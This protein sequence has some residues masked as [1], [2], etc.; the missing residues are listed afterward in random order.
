MFKPSE[1]FVGLHIEIAGL[2]DIGTT[3]NIVLGGLHL[4]N[5]DRT[6]DLEI[7]SI[8][9]S[10]SEDLGMTFWDASFK[11]VD[12]I[13]DSNFGVKDLISKDLKSSMKFDYVRKD[14]VFQVGLKVKIGT[15]EGLIHLDID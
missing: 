14:L 5:E 8:E 2:A 3:H 6:F 10:E 4:S 1:V 9:I 7:S 13:S 15:I 11:E 12:L